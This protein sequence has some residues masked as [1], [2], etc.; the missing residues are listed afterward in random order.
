MTFDAITFSN[1]N[2]AESAKAAAP[3]RFKPIAKGRYN[4][5][6]FDVQIK[7]Y[8]PNSK[9]AGKPYMAIDLVGQSGE[10]KNRHVFPMVP[11]FTNWAVNP[12]PEK[13]KKWPNGF[14]T[15]LVPFLTALGEDLSKKGYKFTP[16]KIDSFLGKPLSAFLGVEFDSYGFNRALEEEDP[17]ALR[18]AELRED[19]GDAVEELAELEEVFSRNTVG[20]YKAADKDLQEDIGDAPTG[21]GAGVTFDN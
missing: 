12:D 9:N 19:A 21:F 8:G 13:A 2:I 18:L 16:A 15:D 20:Q 1:D 11:L 14:P 7:E 5:T 10:A 3:P 6:I 4:F 17:N